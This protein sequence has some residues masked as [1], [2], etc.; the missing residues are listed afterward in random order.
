[1]RVNVASDI[2]LEV[3]DDHAK[4]YEQKYELYEAAIIFFVHVLRK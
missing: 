1:M 4:N 3:P 2:E